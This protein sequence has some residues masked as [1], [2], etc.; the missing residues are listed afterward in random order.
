MKKGFN[1]FTKLFILLLF[2]YT[3]SIVE[4]NEGNLN[5]VLIYLYIILLVTS[6]ISDRY[7]YRGRKSE[8]NKKYEKTS[9]FISL[10][11]FVSLIVP[12]LE[13]AYI[14][15]HNIIITIIGV[16]LVLIGIAVRGIAIKTLGE[17]F[18][19]DVETWSDQEIVRSGIYKYIRHPA[20]AG[21]ILQIIGFPL[22][23]NSYFSLT[24]SLITILGFVWRI[25]VEEKVLKEQI[26][27]YKKYI[28]KTNRIIPKIW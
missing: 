19:R 21:N 15:R 11:W 6:T 12:V 23:L 7:F 17:Y 13:Y 5:R 1:I 25:V 18:S 26:A 22:I 9:Y 20:Y 8:N 14:M 24:L 27:E 10:T 2:F 28:K 3:W 16:L 4:E